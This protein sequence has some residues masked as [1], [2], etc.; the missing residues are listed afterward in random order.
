MGLFT[1]GS[2]RSESTSRELSGMSSSGVVVI[3][4]IFYDGM[5]MI[6]F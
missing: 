4:L 6:L 5:A 3:W 1:G 2:R